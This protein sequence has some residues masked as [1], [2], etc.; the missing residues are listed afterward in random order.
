[1]WSALRKGGVLQS[2]GGPGQEGRAEKGDER[3]HQCFHE[4]EERTIG[5][6]KFE[7]YGRYGVFAE[8]GSHSG[9][10]TLMECCY[11]YPPLPTGLPA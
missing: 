5:G 2:Q 10:G 6:G 3:E 7:G 9:R 4:V 8:Y 11:G 1:M